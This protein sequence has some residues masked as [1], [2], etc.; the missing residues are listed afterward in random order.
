[1][2]IQ[3][4]YLLALSWQ[5][6]AWQLH[7]QDVLKITYDMYKRGRDSGT[8]W[9]LSALIWDNNLLCLEELTVE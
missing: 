3:W 7:Q 2:L 9:L 4:K 5:Q 1:M 6:N 8:G